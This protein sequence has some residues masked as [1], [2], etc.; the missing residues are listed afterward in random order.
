MPCPMMVSVETARWG[1]CCSIAA[2]GRIAMVFS[3]SRPVKSSVVSWSQ[4]TLRIS[5]FLESGHRGAH[6]GDECLA[7]LI[8]RDVHVIERIVV[9]PRAPGEPRHVARHDLLRG[10]ADQQRVPPRPAVGGDAGD[11]LEILQH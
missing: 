7:G 10:I 3:G 2:I 9:D 8:G 5:L 11:A 1:P 4:W 6:S